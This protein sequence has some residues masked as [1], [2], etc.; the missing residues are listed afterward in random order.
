[1]DGITLLK[2]IRRYYKDLP[3]LFISGKTSPEV[4]ALAPPDGYLA[5]PFRISNLEMLIEETLS[6]RYS[7]QEPGHQL[8]V[9]ID[10]GETDL[11]V[12]L[13]DALTDSRYLP[14][15]VSCQTEV[16]RA[17]EC[18]RFDAMITQVEKPGSEKTENVRL[19]RKKYP[20]L[21][22]VLISASYTP[23]EIDRIYDPLKF[24]D[25]L[26]RPINASQLIASLDQA[27]DTVAP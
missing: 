19:L 2:K 25:L 10:V 21:P 22:T 13:N 5:K 3:V 4:A 7:D 8:R 6:A 12:M 15:V 27:T 14:F 1:M 20:S 24:A 23:D 26:L 16:L 17:L 18:G 9:L 11:G